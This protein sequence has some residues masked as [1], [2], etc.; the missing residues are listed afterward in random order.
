MYQSYRWFAPKVMPTLWHAPIKTKRDW[1]N[2]CRLRFLCHSRQHLWARCLLVGTCWPPWMHRPS[3]N[4]SSCHC[5]RLWQQTIR[6]FQWCWSERSN[7]IL[8]V[9]YAQY[10]FQHLNRGCSGRLPTRGDGGQV[11]TDLLK[12]GCFKFHTLAGKVLILRKI[13]SG[14][15]AE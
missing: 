15:W 4:H 10:P 1:L 5:S 2:E 13:Y 6:T 3:N 7:P 9:I 8:E 14:A 12:Y 11:K